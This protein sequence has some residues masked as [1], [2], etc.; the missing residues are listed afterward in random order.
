MVPAMPAR[1]GVGFKPQHLSAI[2]DDPGRLSWFEVHAENYMVEGGPRLRQ[3]ERLRE[4]YPLSLHGVGLSLGGVEPLDTDH[5]TALRQLVDRFEPALVSE[6]VAWSSH[7]GNYFADLLPMPMNRT[8]LDRLINS[9]DQVQEALNRQ[10]LI[11]NPSSYMDLPESNLVEIELLAEV[12]RR[13]GCGLL[14]DVNNIYVSAH[15]LRTSTEAYIDAIPAELV[16]EIH[17]AGHDRSQTSDG[18]VLIDSHS[19]PVDSAV[20]TLYDRLITR[21]GARPTLIEWDNDLPDWP[22]LAGEATRA[23]ALLNAVTGEVEPVA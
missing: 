3:L 7:G 1:S 17:L 16:G 15:N 23:D 2:L 11:E 21:I 5:L 19:R 18:P 12:A 10:I 4:S 22:V 14:V 6:H 13:S 20:W 9:V 8:S